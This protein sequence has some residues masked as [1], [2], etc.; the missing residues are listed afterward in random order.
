M[1]QNKWMLI[2][3]KGEI[4]INALILMG[5]ST[6]R[7]STTAIGYYGSGLKYAISVMVRKEIPFRIYAGMNEH[8][9][10]TKVVK[11]RDK[12]FK[13]ILVNG[14]DTSLTTDMGP[15]WQGWSAIRETVSN[16]I[17]EGESIVVN[18][19]DILQP[20]E[21]YTRIY[22]GHH[23]EVQDVLSNWNRYFSLD[24]TDA[25]VEC[26]MG[27]MFPHI[28]EQE[29][30]LLYRRGIQCYYAKSSK[31]LYEYDLPKITINESRVCD[32]IY[33]A[34]V[35]ATKY[36]VENATKEIARNVLNNGCK[37]KGYWE[38]SMDW[39]YDAYS[40]V[41]NP[42][43]KEAVSNKIL[44]NQDVGGFFTNLLAG[45][46]YMVTKSLAKKLKK[47]FPEV[48]V[49]G[50]GEDGD[51]TVYK[52]HL[53]I[54]PKMQYM[55]KKAGEF[56][57]ECKYTITHDV[58]IVEFNKADTLG[59][60]TDQKILLSNKL[61]DMGMKELV[62]TMIEE[63]EHLCTGHGDCSREMQNHLF[64]KWTSQMEE[65]YGVFL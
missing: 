7:D 47:E 59:R 34:K 56:L 1:K 21:G 29:A 31:S 16:S 43:W 15:D 11:F 36:L 40:T 33:S 2:E 60:A 13:Q 28:D 3:N 26:E 39:Y 53:D 50:V 46:H 44:I 51:D 5:G 17:D 52:E 63:E 8:V 27:K 45:P 37:D 42:A 6:K 30:L 65:Q 38:G 54:T 35:L 64:R 24:R 9:I 62:M 41:M 55:L 23:D 20:K 61:F 25:I 10:T 22:I 32:N 19:T 48:Q 12:E 18:E 49:Y 57:K 4:D 58:E 14:Q